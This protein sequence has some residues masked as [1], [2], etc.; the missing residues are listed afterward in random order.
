M[1]SNYLK[2]LDYLSFFQRKLKVGSF[3]LSR[4]RE[5]STRVLCAAGEGWEH[6][7]VDGVY[8]D[9]FLAG[10]AKNAPNPPYILISRQQLY[11]V[12]SK[13]KEAVERLKKRVRQMK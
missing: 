11:S 12:K 10:G 7:L 2:I 13:P 1:L 6:F 8:P 3:Y 9:M 5:R 4:L